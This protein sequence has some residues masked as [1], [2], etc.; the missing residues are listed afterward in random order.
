MKKRLNPRA[1]AK[2]NAYV[3]G[4]RTLPGKGIQQHTA[5]VMKL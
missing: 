1:F 4:M 2:S 5:H 3:Q